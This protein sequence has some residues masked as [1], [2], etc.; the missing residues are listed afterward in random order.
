MPPSQPSGA[1]LIKHITAFLVLFVLWVTLV[2][3]QA[4]ARRPWNDE[5]MLATPG[6]NLIERGYMGTTVLEQDVLPRIHRY[7][8]WV[9]PLYLVTLAGWYKIVGFSLLKVRAFSALCTLV[10]LA[11]V[12][13]LAKHWLQ[14]ISIAWLSV[15]LLALDYNIMLAASF[16]RYD[17]MV[18]A[19][20]FGAFASYVVIRQRSLPTAL[21][22]SNILVAA[23][24]ITH[25]N[26]LLFLTGL[27]FLV[28]HYDRKSLRVSGVAL[29]AIPYIIGALAW[30][31]YLSHDPKSALAQLTQNSSSRVSLF[32]PLRAIQGE[33][34]RYMSAAGLTHLHSAGAAGP[35]FLKAIPWLAYF[36]AVAFLA[37]SPKLRHRYRTALGLTATIFLYMCF[38][39]GIKFTYYLEHIIPLYT[40]LLA[41]AIYNVWENSRVPRFL[42]VCAIAIAM[43]IGIGGVVQR[44]RLNT[45]QNMYSPAVAFVRQNAGP[46]DL[47]M[48][49]CDFGFSYGFAPNLLDDIRIG[50]HS[51]KIP[52]FIVVEEIYRGNFDG[53]RTA[54]PPLYAFISDRMREYD[55]VYS[56]NT[57]QIYRRKDGLAP[58]TGVPTD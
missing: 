11:E 13:V 39:E 12:Y 23:C 27:I 53:W 10:L 28:L 25:P 26:G 9:F 6:L 49:S 51:S 48:A 3:F 14:S 41:A 54:E 35:I 5:A 30:G 32:T 56:W 38:F 8:Y 4:R 50:Y 36:A 34:G 47:V 31:Y 44:I 58:Q 20:G 57:Y 17:P 45:F 18:A 46:T 7:T 42:T 37:L 15:M 19:L 24:G 43:S 55:L 29:A 16:G 40:M 2:Y 1:R 52:Q 33:L 21:L 22:V